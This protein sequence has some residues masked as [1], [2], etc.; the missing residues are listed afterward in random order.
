MTEEAQN[1]IP[2]ENFDAISKALIS[3]ANASSKAGAASHISIA[4]YHRHVIRRFLDFYVDEQLT[5]AIEY[6]QKA[7]G[8]VKGKEHLIGNATH[9]RLKFEGMITIVDE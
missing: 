7:A 4:E 1:N 8:K 6:A 3:A 2:R 5:S 9:F